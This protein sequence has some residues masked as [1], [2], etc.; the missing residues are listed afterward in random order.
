[1]ARPQP[2]VLRGERLLLRPLEDRDVAALAAILAEPEVSRWWG[3]W[4]E[5]RVREELL[6]DDEEVVLAVEVEGE[7]AGLL[8]WYEEPDPEYRHA[9]L[10]VSLRAVDQ[11]KGLGPEALRLAIAYLIDER[12]HHRLTIDP[13]ASNDRA[14]R[15]Y[16]AVGF[17]PVGVMRHYE[18]GADG[19]W[20]DGLLMDLLADEFPAL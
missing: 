4:D 5:P 18:R 19:E 9:A 14:I 12:G 8:Q 10:D 20:H 2:P 13:A 6:A 11:G 3:R 1:M 17:K 16:A 7:V 15:A